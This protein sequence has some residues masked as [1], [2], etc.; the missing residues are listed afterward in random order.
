M[1]NPI[2]AMVN[3]RAVYPFFRLIT[4]GKLFFNTALGEQISPFDM[5][6]IVFDYLCLL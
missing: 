5:P 1:L 2:S 4:C 3:Y 6:R